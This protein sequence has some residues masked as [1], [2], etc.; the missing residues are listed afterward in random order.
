MSRA[1]K[2]FNDNWEF[3]L[4]KPG[5]TYKED[6]YTPVN[7]PHDWLIYDCDNLYADGTGYYKKIFD[8][9]K[10]PGKKYYINFDGVYMDSTVY[11][12][13]KEAG[14]N[15]Y[16]YSSFEFDITDFLV[17]G[18]NEIKVEIRHKS[19][20]T[21]WYSGAGIFRDVTFIEVNDIHIAGSGVYV[22]TE[23]L[24]GKPS[25]EVKI[26]GIK[27][28]APNNDSQGKSD[29]GKWRVT[30]DIEVLGLDE[31]TKK[32]IEFDFNIAHKPVSSKAGECICRNVD[33][34]DI[35]SYYYAENTGDK[36]DYSL[37]DSNASGSLVKDEYGEYTVFRNEFVIENGRVWDITSPEN[38]LLEIT[39]KY[40]GE[41]VDTFITGFGLRTI[42]YTTDDGFFLNGRHVKINGVCEH[43]D[44]GLFGA[45]F[46]KDAMRRKFATLKQMGV[47]A[48]RTSHNMPAKLLM[49]LA[50]EMGIMIDSEAFDMWRRPKTEYDYA[51]FFEENYKKDIRSWVRRDRNHPSVIMWSIGNEIY[52]C[53]ADETAPELTADMKKTVETYDY[54]INAPATHASN[55]MGWAG[56][57]KCADVLKMAG[58]N[59][60]ERL[61]DE[62]HKDHPDWKIYG[63]ETCSTVQSRGIYHFPLSVSVMADD[64]EQC[65]SL[66]NCTTS[67]GAPSTEYVITMDRDRKYSQG[68]FLWTGFDYIG[69]PTPY[70]TKNSYFGQIDTAGF[71]KDTYY[72]F[73]SSW[74]DAKKAPFVHI[75]PYWDFNEGQI[76]DVRAASNCDRVALF[77]KA[78][79][80][81]NCQDINDNCCGKSNSI[82]DNGTENSLVGYTLIGESDLDHVNG[83]VVAPAWQI[84]YRKGILKAVAYMDGEIAAVTEVK[85]FGDAVALSVKENFKDGDTIFL[86]IFA[87]DENGI[88]VEN[89]SN[90]VK[91]TVEGAGEL[92][93]LDNGDSTD[94]D[95]Y[96]CDFRRLFSGKLLAAISTKGRSGK[97]KVTVSSVGLK[98]AEY[99]SDINIENSDSNSSSSD[100]HRKSNT[101]SFDSTDK[102]FEKNLK[103]ANISDELLNEVPVRNIKL[104]I[105]DGDQFDRSFNSECKELT[106]KAVICPENA[107]YSDIKWVAVNEKAV[108]TNIVDVEP[109]DTVEGHFCKLKAKGDGEFRLRA[110]CYNGERV[111]K[112]ISVLE[113]KITGLGKAFIN[114]YEFIS[115]SLY[116]DSNGEIGNGNEKGIATPR[117]EKSYF[118]FE[119]LDF[120][121]IG[122]DEVTVPIFTLNDSE[123][124]LGIWEGRP[125]EPGSTFL[126]DGRY[127]KKMIW[128]TYQPETFKLNKKLTGV[129]SIYFTADD[130]YH[131]KGFSF[132]EPDKA[133]ETLYLKQRSRI[134]GDTFTVDGDSIT[135]IGNNVTIEFDGMDFGDTPAKK[136]VICGRSKL[137]NN[138]IHL[139]FDG[140]EGVKTEL[141]E[142][143][144]SDTYVEREFDISGTIG[145]NT[146]GFVFLPGCDFDFKYFKFVR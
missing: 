15:R 7:I 67:W 46:N 21:R 68:Q 112:V 71:P 127:C 107:T 126:C 34:S 36:V 57:R 138:S 58:Y 27:D 84:S 51:R 82:S 11:V 144:G 39:L 50:D 99:S 69:E 41:T 125:N 56:A 86:E 3:Q 47:N 146:V 97:L 29:R 143:A 61:Y 63:S 64:D 44:F 74:T 87:V 135:G 37:S 111:A 130:K 118:G 80:A 10:K 43:H 22:F 94:N 72:L 132:K 20:N 88:P 35:P 4:V 8:L 103:N 60:G 13:G 129:T 120:G 6:G 49:E 85:S 116:T 90:R 128:N 52:D 109:F 38:Y 66:G 45:A 42:E 133:Y 75:F 134:Y 19:P 62:Q 59:Y 113:F 110:L 2:L 54:E 142:F 95:N 83:N 25:Y 30:A 28:T 73:K 79:Y 108:P 121:E 100:E 24:S 106:I 32:D 16:G 105:V 91:V 96:K 23:L 53:H 139:K 26:P 114:P 101:L 40:K 98:P 70:H 123:Y 122:S 77:F 48:V 33:F 119:N 12:N 17:N 92:A 14:V 81:L 89:A 93:G 115:G 140:E 136:L 18:E 104:E 31:S 76:I 1:E 145:K 102:F 78:E 124:K 5:E 117:G 131:F 55:F 65:S 141:I 137:A 9:A